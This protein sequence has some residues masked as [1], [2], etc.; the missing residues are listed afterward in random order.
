MNADL[1]GVVILKTDSFRATP[2]AAIWSGLREVIKPPAMVQH[3]RIFCKT[4][5]F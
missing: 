3:P 2:S 5:S 4:R 1:L